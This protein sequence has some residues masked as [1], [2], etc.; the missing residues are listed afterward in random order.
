MTAVAKAPT[1]G[2]ATPADPLLTSADLAVIF[3][4]SAATVR[5]WLAAGKLP[6]P[7]RLGGQ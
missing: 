1:A 5:A 7:S 4:V 3:R 2:P 6:R